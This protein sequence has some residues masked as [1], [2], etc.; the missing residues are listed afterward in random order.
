M[1]M[2][3]DTCRGQ[4]RECGELTQGGKV[5]AGSRQSSRPDFDANYDHDIM[6]NYGNPRDNHDHNNDHDDNYDHYNDNDKHE[7]R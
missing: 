1:K 3:V 5:P 2:N 4:A 6:T 7:V